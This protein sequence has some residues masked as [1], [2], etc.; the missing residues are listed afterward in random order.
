[1]SQQ[2]THWKLNEWSVY[3]DLNLLQ[4]HRTEFVIKPRLMKLLDYFLRHQ[5]EVI[6]REVILEQVWKGRMVTEN[7]LTK[8]ISELRKLLDAH[9]GETIQIETIRNVGYR[10]HADFEISSSSEQIDTPQRKHKQRFLWAALFVGLIMIALSLSFF[11]AG[12][13]QNLTATTLSPVS[14]LR[15]QELSPAISPDGQNMAFAWR[16]TTDASFQIYLRPMAESTPRKLNEGND[17]EFNPVWSPDGKCIAY[18]KHGK[19]GALLLMKKSVIGNESTELARLDGLTVERG[20]IWLEAKNQLVFSARQ[21]ADAS[22]RLYAFDF[23]KGSLYPLTDPPTK[24]YGDIYPTY[25][26]S[27]QELVFVRA[28][29]GKSE[30]SD[31]APTQ[32][33]LY[34][35]NLNSLEASAFASFD[36]ELKEVVYHPGLSHYLC[37]VYK[38]LGHNELWAVDQE[39]RKQ[40]LRSLNRGLPGESATGPGNTLYFEYW[41]SGVD[42]LAYPMHKDGQSLGSPAEY[43]NSTQWDWG[44]RFAHKANKCAFISMRNGYQEVW[45]APKDKPSLAWQVTDLKGAVIQSLSISADGEHILFTVIENKKGGLYYIRANGMGLKRLTPE[46]ADFSSPE[47]LA[48]SRH[49]YYSSNKGG[50][51]NLYKRDMDGHYDERLTTSGGYTCFQIPGQSEPVFFIKPDADT[52]WQ[53]S[54]DN[55]AV[56]PVCAT[57]GMEPFNWVP[58]ENGIYY[59]AWQQGRCYLYFFDFSSR[60]TTQLKPLENILPGIPALAIPPDGQAIYMSQSQEVNADILSL[61]ISN[62]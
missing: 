61:E 46:G 29:P 13:P 1:M 23:K 53:L 56:T 38:R 44:L 42:V 36:H 37:W 25:S 22:R 39:G 30:F 14:S 54:L 52:I 3:P 16:G 20:M 15:G 24:S 45:V 32:G 57:P 10:L 41:Q 34:R 2:D 31:D 12:Q 48:D 26:Q 60:A 55:E 49:F 50:E 6:S 58:R 47:W 8:S 11:S 33:T 19:Q 21:A 40:M 4:N 7:L 51:W 35:L 59:L 5:D 43:L 27:D 9:F 62:H 18:M 28:S 17:S